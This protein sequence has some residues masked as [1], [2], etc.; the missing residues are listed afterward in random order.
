MSKI[1][2]IGGGPGGLLAAALIRERRPDIEV[3]LFER[4]GSDES[5]GFGV[6]FSA[7]KLARLVQEDRRLGRELADSGRH[8][9]HID[10]HLAGERVRC[11]GLGFSAIS[12]RSLLGLL[13]ARAREAGVELRFRTEA[14]PVELARSYDLVVG[15]DGLNS[16]TRHAHA[17]RFG[18]TVDHASARYIWFGA[19]RPFDSMTFLFEE[20]EAGWFAVHAYPYDRNTST[21]VVECDEP[22][23]RR[24]GFDDA[25]ALPP[26]SS[27]ENSRLRLERIFATQLDGAKLLANH[28]RWQTFRTV[29]ARSW[30]HDRTVLLGDA[31]HTAH[32]SVGSGTTMALEDALALADQVTQAPAAGLGDAIRAYEAIRRPKVAR[33]Q[34]AAVPS[35]SWWENFADYARHEPRRFAVHFLTRSGRV[36][37]D[38]LAAGDPEFGAETLRWYGLPHSLS[39][40]DTPIEIGS[41]VFPG[42]LVSAA[43]VDRRCAEALWTTAPA[44]TGDV[45]AFISR[46]ARAAAPPPLL[47][48]RAAGPGLAERTAA[49]LV[50]ELA[51]L[52]LGI[53]AALITGH[54]DPEWAATYLLTA[55]ADLLVTSEPDTGGTGGAGAVR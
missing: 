45:P 4:N 36:S 3:E 48:I 24:A 9:D 18:P 13:R 23:W 41:A 30:C 16:R 15:A 5:F 49:V 25:G 8:W 21:F 38:R 19:D 26:G 42:R 55:R 50:A 17:G 44:R 31:A 34:D 35:L 14:D 43:E 47:V 51:K 40:L 22:T 46:L 6:V 54:P 12:R 52:R 27:D 20:T 1:A 37:F 33:V 32:F 53:P 2:V 39:I 29:R 11:G 7:L 28:S 10:V